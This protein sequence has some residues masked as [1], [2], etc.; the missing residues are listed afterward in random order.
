M[1]LSLGLMPIQSPPAKRGAGAHRLDARHD[2][3][4]AELGGDA[5]HRAAGRLGDGAQRLGVAED[6]GELA[7]VR[8]ADADEGDEVAGAQRVQPELARRRLRRE[9]AGLLLGERDGAL[10]AARAE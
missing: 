9:Q 8:R 5:A 3:A 10:G 4:V 7:R 6:V 1:A 2:D